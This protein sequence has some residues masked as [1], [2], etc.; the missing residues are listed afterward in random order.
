MNIF[1]DYPDIISNALIPMIIAI[2]ALGL[3]LL[4]QTI[5]RID[6]KYKSP[7]LI[8]YFRKELI[9]TLFLV[10]LGTAILS[11]ILWFLQIP[12]CLNWGWLIDNL[13]VIFAII[14]T[15]AL[16]VMTFLIAQLIY[17]YF[18][19]SQL[20]NHFIR[21]INVNTDNKVKYY[22]AISKILNYSLLTID[23]PLAKK[24]W[25]FYFTE[26]SKIIEGK[27]GEEIV[28]PEEI[29]DTFIEANEILCKDNKKAISLFNDNTIFD[30]F[31][32][33]HKETVISKET[34]IFL[35]KLLLQ[36]IY[37]NRNDFVLSYWQKAHQLFSFYMPI[38]QP[39]YDLQHTLRI[40]NQKEIDERDK[41]REDF[42]EFHYVLGALLMYKQQY[43][44]IKEI[45]YYTHSQPPRYVLVPER[46]EEVIKQYMQI[47]KNDYSQ[48]LFYR[49]K[50]WFPDIHGVNSEDIIKMWI[51][52]YFAILFIRQYTL[53][54]YY[55]YSNTLSMPR[56]PQ[57]L[58]ELNRWKS[59]LDDL[60]YYVNEYLNKVRILKA[61]GLEHLSN[62]NWFTENKK[63]EPNNLINN[64]KIEIENKFDDIKS[65]QPISS[66]KEE[67]FKEKTKNILRP[68]FQ[69]YSSIFQN[70]NIGTEH[71]KYSIRGQHYILPKTAFTNNTDITYINTD[72]ITA[73]AVAQE[74]Q[75]YTLN[76]FILISS[77]KYLLVEK[78]LFLALDK[79]KINSDEFVI[80]SVGL[81]LDYLKSFS[82]D[83]LENKKGKWFYKD[84]EIIEIDYMNELVSQSLFI[85]RKEDIPNIIF[86]EIS[87]QEYLKKFNLDKIDET[88]NIY[89]GLNDLNEE[90]KN[91]LKEEIAKKS[92][93][94]K[95]SQKTLA[96]VDINVEIQCKKNTKCV[97]LKVFSQFDDRGRINSIDEVNSLWNNNN[98]I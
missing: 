11:Y 98:S 73:E 42:L 31:L 76:I 89:A 57:E 80:I 97:Q 5:T 77:Q 64:Y 55:I 96:C 47:G 79:L 54:E 51:K 74:F 92:T 27:E 59:E 39:K 90:N 88:F 82:N 66:S 34:Y 37:H 12:S 23:E 49:Q 40:I 8:E 67:I 3:P 19:P 43:S 50:Y 71:Q 28:Y 13:A 63:I 7:T 87:D 81:Y 9:T 30:L 2:F 86:K 65:Q 58:S 84:I 15:V 41:A 33:N 62:K 21:K 22:Q 72:T 44:V 53:H 68:I 78:D 24:V 25:K 16:V 52:R 75:Y 45:M 17:V 48:P 83:E 91:T 4:I 38:I 14:N 61:L 46:M 1:A 35:W 70:K 26:F 56:I 10:F 18:V 20:I 94:K 29:Y 6:D 95:L 32:Y 69:K 85:L 93:E 36:C 60:Q